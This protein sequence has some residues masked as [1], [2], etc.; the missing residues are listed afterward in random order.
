MSTHCMLTFHCFTHSS[1]DY[2]RNPMMQILLLSPICKQ[3]KEVLERLN[4]SPEFP[5][6]WQSRVSN[7]N[8]IP[9]I[10][11]EHVEGT[12]KLKQ[13]EKGMT[14]LGPGSSLEFNHH[15]NTM[16]DNYFLIL[17]RQVR[18]LSQGHRDK[19][20]PLR[21]LFL[22][23]INTHREKELTQLQMMSNVW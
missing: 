8:P 1:F 2:R 5:K 12:T 7:P 23:G 19:L 17:V 10:Q 18:K 22:L 21:N 20:L 14:Y 13:K 15:N 16:K 4:M 6:E 9:G 11:H 3:E